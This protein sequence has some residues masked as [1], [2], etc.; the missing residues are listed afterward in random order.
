MHRTLSSLL[1]MEVF[2]VDSHAAGR[3]TDVFLDREHWTISYIVVDAGGLLNRNEHLLTPE[4]IRLVLPEA[5]RIELN[6]SREKLEQAPD[7]KALEYLSRAHGREFHV[8]FGAP[9]SWSHNEAWRN[10]GVAAV[11][12]PNATPLPPVPPPSDV[13]ELPQALQAA[14]DLLARNLSF[15][16]LQTFNIRTLNSD[17]GRI[18]NAVFQET[19]LHVTHAVVE[20]RRWLAD[21]AL[22]FPL[23]MIA[24]L[25]VVERSMELG[26]EDERMLAAPEFVG[27]PPYVSTEYLET[28]NHHFER[29]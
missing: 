7:L 21:R 20:S 9:L 11:P 22:C 3:V 29:L 26:L 10:S 14:D 25:D 18:R 15:R 16:T 24:R 5:G 2:T 13:H 1:G 27:E 19:G 4:T 8:D 28:V 17:L 6:V 12:D 23:G